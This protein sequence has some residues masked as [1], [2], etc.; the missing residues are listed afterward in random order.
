MS[1]INLNASENNRFFMW[2]N[3]GAVYMKDYKLHETLR[4]VY[5][6]SDIFCS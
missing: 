5:D 2:Y 6:D 1:V 3:K 4:S